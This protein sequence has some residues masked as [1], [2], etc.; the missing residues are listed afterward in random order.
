MKISCEIQGCPQEK[1]V[2]WFVLV[3]HSACEAREVRWHAP[4]ENFEILDGLRCNL[5]HSQPCIL[6]VWNDH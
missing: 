1:K 2:E 3:V 6:T 5:V 4:P